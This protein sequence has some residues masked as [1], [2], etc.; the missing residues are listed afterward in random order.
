[1]NDYVMYKYKARISIVTGKEENMFYFNVN[2]NI[3]DQNHG[4]RSL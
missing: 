3:I 1:M 4:R 2:K